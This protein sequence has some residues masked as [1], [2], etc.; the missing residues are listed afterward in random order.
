MSRYILNQKDNASRA[1]AMNDISNRSTQYRQA[2]Y[3]SME[4]NILNDKI[5]KSIN[6]T[7][8][9]GING[10]PTILNSKG[11]KVSDMAVRN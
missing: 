10:T 2:K 9:I 1:K 3:S 7:E 4:L 11:V 6:E 5:E 8:K